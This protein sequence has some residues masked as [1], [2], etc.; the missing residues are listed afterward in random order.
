MKYL[1]YYK[2]K[3][4]KDE[5][6]VFNFF[7]DNLQDTIF[8]WDYFVDW[9]KIRKKVID[10]EDEL[11]LLN[12]LIG[13]DNS[14]EKF[15][16]LVERYPRIK[17]ALSLLVAVRGNKLKE[18]CIINKED[19]GKPIKEWRTEFKRDYFKVRKE[20]DNKT[21]E[22]LL[23][24]YVNSGLKEVFENK[25]VKNIKDYYFGVEAGMDTNARKNRTG[26]LMEEMVYKYLKK[27]FS[28]IIPQATKKRIRD[29]WGVELQLRS[30]KTNKDFDF[31]ILENGKVY[32]IEVNYY[33][34]GGSKLKSTAGEY[35]DYE[36][37][38]TESETNADFI[39]ITDGK[40]WNTAKN[41]L[42]ETFES[43][44]YVFNLKMLTEGILTEVIK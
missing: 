23:K 9:D 7:I 27:D 8:T 36:R 25:D 43:N 37:F 26:T 22:E 5:E 35:K 17:K 28:K 38:I 30:I 29:E 15:I 39:W 32:L 16:Q 14:E 6:D 40:G 41:P 24:F 18:I 42:K 2:D 20:V 19:V 10:V 31:A 11:N 44:K 1:N 13:K 4:L 12:G 3:N 34:G 21:K 33:S